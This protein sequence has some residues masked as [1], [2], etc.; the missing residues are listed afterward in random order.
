MRFVEGYLDPSSVIR[1]GRD[2]DKTFRLYGTIRS[3]KGSAYYGKVFDRNFDVGVEFVPQKLKDGAV[4]TTCRF[5]GECG[6][7]Q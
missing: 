3:F 6:G 2:L 4:M 7:V 5:S 1:V